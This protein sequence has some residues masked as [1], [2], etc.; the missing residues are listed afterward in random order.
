MN[1]NIKI[2]G[3][4]SSSHANGNSASLTKAA[5]E[6]AAEEGA[7]VTE[8]Y[9]SKLRLEFCTGCLQ[10]LA[11]ECP[12]QDDFKTIRNLVYEADGI[13]LSSPTFAAAPNAIMKNFIDRLGMY[14]RFTSSLG[15]KYVAAISTAGKMGAKNTAESLVSIARDGIFQ[16]GYVSGLLGVSI[17]AGLKEDDNAFIKAHELGRKITHD[18]KTGNKYLLQNLWG[19]FINCCFVKPQFKQVI[20]DNKTDKMKWVYRNLAERGLL[21]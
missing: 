18:V 11:G 3:V 8:V 13:I 4:I 2:V 14:E 7:E 12:F 9:L 21:Q 1:K 10:C 16:R 5:L 19:R 17:G 15:G 20:L 6:G